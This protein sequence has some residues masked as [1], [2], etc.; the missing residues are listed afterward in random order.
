MP[1]SPP[2]RLVIIGGRLRSRFSD[3]RSPCCCQNA[4]WRPTAARRRRPV[5]ALESLPG[6]WSDRSDHG[7]RG[8]RGRQGT[9]SSGGCELEPTRPVS[10]SGLG[11][12]DQ[13][14]VRLC[15][16]HSPC[17]RVRGRAQLVVVFSKPEVFRQ[18]FHD[19]NLEKVSAL[20]ERDF[21]GLLKDPSIIRN[22]AKIVR[23]ARAEH[24][25][26]TSAA[27]TRPLGLTVEIGL[28]L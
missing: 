18:A 5:L 10:R 6:C 27:A 15:S 22:R 17:W 25:D 7:S 16:K 26:S 8:W 28:T 19:F 2:L 12:A 3:S 11:Q 20:R 14:V 9:L 4:L 13:E 24:T 1:D 21:D 23:R